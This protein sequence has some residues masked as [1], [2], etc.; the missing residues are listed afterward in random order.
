MIEPNPNMWR[1]RPKNARAVDPIPN[2]WGLSPMEAAVIDLLTKGYSMTEVAEK[3][4]LSIKTVSTY[5]TRCGE[6]MA[7][8]NGNIPTS[9]RRCVL[10]Y[11]ETTPVQYTLI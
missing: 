6:K 8:A 4:C 3:L 5:F 10:W 7:D 2:K 11:A 1:E 9:F